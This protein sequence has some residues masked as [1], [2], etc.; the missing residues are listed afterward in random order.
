MDLATF[1]LFAVT[2]LVVIVT[3]GPAAIAVVSMTAGNGFSRGVFV[4]AGVACANVIFFALSAAGISAMI[5]ASETIFAVIKW[6]GVGY[7]LYLGLGAITG[8]GKALTVTPGAKRPIRSLFA[9]GFVVEFANPKA[10]LYFAAILPQ[11]LDT[12]APITPQIVI[13]GTTTLILDCT[14]YAAYAALGHGIAQ[15]GISGR[16]VKIL[17]RCAGGALLFAAYKMARVA[18]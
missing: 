10:L 7:L 4:I 2:T 5:V 6:V 1:L 14:V 16:M 18:T 15:S 17:D 9:R 3:P 8:K 11:F 12:A 13:M